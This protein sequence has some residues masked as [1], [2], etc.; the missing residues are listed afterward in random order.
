MNG[1]IYTRGIQIPVE[2]P[3][4][5]LLLFYGL[6]NKNMELFRYLIIHS[7]LQPRR[8]DLYLLNKY[9]IH[10]EQIF[11]P[12]NKY[13]SLL[14]TL[15]RNIQNLLNIDTKNNKKSGA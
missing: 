12:N 14:Q 7:C 9:N 10:I 8:S 15:M 3:E 2:I 5:I 6:I 1:Q 4:N 13:L 11:K